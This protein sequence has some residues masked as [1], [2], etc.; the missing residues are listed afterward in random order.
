MVADQE[1]LN[2]I[3]ASNFPLV[4]FIYQLIKRALKDHLKSD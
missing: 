2:A 4:I 1:F 3:F